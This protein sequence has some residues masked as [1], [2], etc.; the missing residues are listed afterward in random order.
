M[1][2][3]GTCHERFAPVQQTF[4]ENFERFADIGAS[5]AV[6]LEGEMVVDLWAGH[7]DAARQQPWAADTIVNVYSTTKTMTAL[8][9]LVLVDRGE[10]QLDAPVM[11]YW[12][13][14]AAAGKEGV[15]VRHLLSHSAGLPG[16]DI[17]C[18]PPEL[19]DWDFVCNAL[20]QQT[21]WWTPGEA[22]GY[23]AL[24]QGHLIGEVVRRITGRSLGTFFREEIAQPL[25]ADF[26]IGVPDD[27]L[28]RIADLVPGVRQGDRPGP[29]DGE[30]IAA[31]AF[32]S[33]AAGPKASATVEWRR[34]EIP[35]ANGHGNARAVVRAQTPMANGGRAWGVELLSSAGAARVFEEQSSSRDLV[36]KVPIRW[37]LGYGLNS[38]VVPIGPNEHICYWGGWGGSSVVVDQDARVCYSYVMNKMINSLLGD[39]R[40]YRIG[41]A[42]YRCLAA[43]G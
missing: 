5:V 10:L 38:K 8:C 3:H 25:G 4:E 27:V 41:Q 14:F 21:P 6:S 28:P 34:A 20:A 42:V 7:R 30:S 2:I 16:L 9:V 31:R 15:L 32:A 26:H 29:V 36:L 23:H 43:A 40:G 12:P 19:Y 11:R 13:E 17:A 22:S 33:P 37:G 24:T 18:G 39:R 35:A 1:E